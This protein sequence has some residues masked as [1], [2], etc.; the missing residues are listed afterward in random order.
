MD[1]Y[2]LIIYSLLVLT[3]IFCVIAIIFT[4]MNYTNIDNQIISDNQKNYN[5]LDTLIKNF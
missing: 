2:K 1:K 5:T 4:I 3:F